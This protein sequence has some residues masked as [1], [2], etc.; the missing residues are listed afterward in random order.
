[1]PLMGSLYIGVSGLQTS[2]N[3]LNTTA[4]NISNIGTTGYV[5]QQVL[6]GTATYDTILKNNK[7]VA[8]QQIGLGVVYSKTRQVRDTFLDAT[9]RKEAGRSAFYEVSY[10][11]IGEIESLLDEMNGESFE[12]TISN[13]WVAVQELS[14]DPSSAVTQG[15]FVE[16]CSEF[17]ARAQSVYSGLKSY[18]SSLN[19]TVKTNVNRINE[20]AGQI[21]TLNDEIRNI[22][23]T[24]V[25][26]EGVSFEKANDLR[27]ARNTLLDELS[28]YGNITYSEDTDCTVWVQLEGEDLVRGEIAYKIGLYE[29]PDTGFYTPFWEKNA[30][31]EID[32]EGKRV[33]T[34]EEAEKAKVFDLTKVI[35]SDL[36][37]DI[38][39]LKSAL[40]ARGYKAADYTDL[41]PDR[42]VNE[43]S[44]SVCMNTMAEFDQLVHGITTTINKIIEE[45]AV[46]AVNK[47]NNYL[48]TYD[49]NLG[50]Y[51]PI[52]VF[53]K[54]ASDGYR[55]ESGV[56]TYNEEE[57]GTYN[58]LTGK[59]SG[60]VNE[61]LYT[62]LNI[63]INA[64]LLRQ[65]TKLGFVLADD[66]VDYETVA[67]IKA[68]FESEDI[69]LNPNVK[70]KSSFVDYYGDLV[71][72]VANSGAVYKS[73]LDSQ[74]ATVSAA[75]NAREQIIGVSQDEELTFMIKFQ[76]AYNAS[77]RYINVVDEMLEHI[78]NTLGV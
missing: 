13:L 76:N 46:N 57:V 32:A 72:Q 31:F 56:I 26:A 62:T 67:K 35:S 27:D 23:I 47:Q 51:V 66:S 50:T 17:V 60:Y 21:K 61:S 18:Q 65:P 68:A 12:E 1:M 58:S 22:E 9:Y 41:L 40:L 2:Q 42:Y 30:K 59:V 24:N 53:Q 25:G 55:N 8:N 6:T 63:Q 71:S 34:A 19:Q 45:A 75:D 14:K 44:Q 37:T 69:T 4:H 36:N 52:Q 38:G 20:I 11:A 78:I 74:K 43:V 16:R 10:D 70:K 64:E 7:S 33:Y 28:T 54:I 49:N 3:S 15:L 48:M 5:R 77:S 73:L 39:A 29:A